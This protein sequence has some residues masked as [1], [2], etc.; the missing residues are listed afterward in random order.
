MLQFED[1]VEASR[2]ANTP[3]ELAQLY[4]ETIGAEGYENC[5]LTSFKGRN[6]EKIA[7]FRFPDGYVDAYLHHR[8]QRID[9]VLGCSLRATRPFFWSDVTDRTPLSKKQIT[10]LNE[11]HDLKVH[12]GISFPFHGPHQSLDLI[13]ISRRVP[14]PPNAEL[15]S[16]LHAISLQ[17]WARYQELTQQTLFVDPDKILT[18]R[19]LEIL[20]WC[21]DG[22]TRPEI[23]EILSISTKTVE[24]HL[25]NVMNKLG[26]NNQ[27]SA[28]VIGLQRG[29]IEL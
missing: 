16:L 11:C 23:G 1:Y 9:P 8:W 6:V 24:F 15:A 5:V 20:R 2:R 3:A 12:T 19:E 10:F 13:S 4:A 22:K 27:I 28:V 17:T 29:L 25:R 21:K 7:W 26:A 14:E 18:Q